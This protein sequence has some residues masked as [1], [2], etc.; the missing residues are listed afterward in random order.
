MNC[1]S[2]VMRRALLSNTSVHPSCLRSCNVHTQTRQSHASR[3]SLVSTPIF[4]VNA[5]P[6]LGHLYTV[7]IADAVHR[8]HEMQGHASHLTTGTD[9]HGLKIQQAASANNTSP[10]QFCDLNSAHFQSLFDA[11]NI[12]YTKFI[13]TTDNDHINAVQHFY[14]CLVER[15][16]VYKGDYSGWYC[17]SDESFLTESQVV[18]HKLANGEFIKVS[19]ESLN[20]VE[21]STEI[22]Y[23]FK[24]S[25]SKSDL[26]YW[27]KSD[28]RVKPKR[29]LEDLRRMVA[30]DLFDL[31]IS[32]PMERV[33]W[34]VP[35][36]DDPAHSVYVWVDALVN[37]L[38]AVGYP[39]TTNFIWP[40]N[41]QVLGKDI[42]KFHGIYWPSL[43]MA[44]GLEPPRQLLVHSHWTVDGVKMSKSL[45]NVVCPRQAIQTLSAD[46]VRYCLLRQGTP[47]S[48][49]S[50]REAEAISLVNAEL[51][52]TLGN[53][54][55]RC[56]GKALNTDNIF[57][58]IQPE[59]MESSPTAKELVTLL[60]GLGSEVAH[61]YEEYNFYEGIECIM[62]AVRCANLMVQEEKPWE[63]KS[64]REHLDSVVHLALS[65]GHAAALLLQ[66][67]VPE[68]ASRLLDTLGVP[69]HMR[70]WGNVDRFPCIKHMPTPLG[71]RVAPFK[72]IKL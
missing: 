41:C 12:S 49:G 57:P 64:D 72:K 42:L 2:Y 22:N 66:P 54:V 37:Y 10:Q 18:N 34:G 32:R 69:R 38:S 11:S 26:E 51:A 47:H 33:S 58:S 29:F 68:Y 4:Y 14:R 23:K 40:P 61:C 52:D 15:G 13:R 16:H 19:S 48:D 53:L 7:T 20:P 63:L 59:F 27:L 39:N 55:H 60:A 36:P 5:A 25:Q 46:G 31:S 1:L 45:G 9:E 67:I 71:V 43:L 24:L 8:F 3:E 44:A 62:R 70:T 28:D 30:G 17:V 50:W 35:V 21:W 6:H 65:A 56:T